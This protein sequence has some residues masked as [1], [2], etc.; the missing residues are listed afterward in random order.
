V[1]SGRALGRP[2]NPLGR[3]RDVF[4]VGGAEVLVILLVALLVLGPAKLPEAA[5]QVGKAMAELR[6]LSGGFQAE[7]RDALAEPLEA[8]PRPNPTL[9]AVTEEGEEGE[10]PNRAEEPGA[11]EQP[12]QFDHL[13]TNGEGGPGDAG[14]SLPSEPST[15]AQSEDRPA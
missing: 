6:R 4:N 13:A 1:S 14:S 15:D 2:G 3:L 8:S 7:L 9:S 12:E 10:Q 11:P 5:R